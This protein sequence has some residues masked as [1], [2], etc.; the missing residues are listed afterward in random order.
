MLQ[1]HPR[2]SWLERLFSP[3]PR[4]VVTALPPVASIRRR[5]R[6]ILVSVR[7][8]RATGVV[9]ASCG[10][11]RGVRSPVQR[12]AC[13]GPFGLLDEGDGVRSGIPHRPEP[14]TIRRQVC[15][16]E[17]WVTPGVDEGRTSEWGVE[18]VHADQPEVLV[19]RSEVCLT[20]HDRLLLVHRVIVEGW[21]VAQRWGSFVSALT[22]G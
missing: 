4:P 15:S 18:S 13:P 12:R 9:A 17:M 7:L 22:V 20:V 16:A 3:G 14:P 2:S 6:P 10:N 11:R 21:A 1:F 8:R 19:S 5:R